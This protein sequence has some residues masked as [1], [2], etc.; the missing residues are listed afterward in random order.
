MNTIASRNGAHAE[1]IST[2][3]SGD[4][5]HA[6][7]TETLASGDNSHTEGKWSVADGE[8][9]HAQGESTRALGRYSHAEGYG[10]YSIGDAS[11]TEGGHDGSPTSNPTS[12]TTYS[13]HAEGIGTISSGIA[14]HAE[15]QDTEASGDYSHAEG[16]ETNATNS[17]SHTEGKLTIASGLYSH[18]Q[19]FSTTAS[20][21]NAHA[22]GSVTIAD[23][24]HSHAEGFNTKSIGLA[25]HSGGQT[26]T[27]SGSTSFVHSTNSLVTG[28]RSVVLGGQNITGTTHDTVYV[29]KLNIGT[30][31]TGTSLYNLGINSDGFVVTGTTG[32]GGGGGS[33]T[34]TGNTINTCITDLYVSDLY[35]CTGSSITTVHNSLTIDGHLAA[36]SKSFE[37]DH[38]TKEGKKL[39]HGSLEGPEH[40]VYVRGEL[41]DDNIIVLPDYWKGLV[42]EDSITVQLTAIG[43]AFIHY[44]DEIK[45]YEVYVDCDGGLPH[46]YYF[47]QGERKD[48]DKLQ[49]EK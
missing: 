31:Y 25:S 2:V 39:I 15:G 14:S 49:I 19:G 6:E 45:D 21:V 11:H 38:P 46:C 43:K 22:E 27:A 3:A 41:K 23:G 18:A 17:A 32:G 48:V 29:P 5:A 10:N 28:D 35:T 1:G 40:G 9:S 36:T 13:S 12:A 30:V 26:S 16:S 33:G 44:V 47:I 34:F 20:G 4:S 8:T 42:E 37:I 7:G 24:S